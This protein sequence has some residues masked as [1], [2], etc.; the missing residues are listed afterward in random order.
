MGI[1]FMVL[2]PTS[3]L[4]FPATRDSETRQALCRAYN[5]YQAAMFR[6]FSDRLAP[7]AVIPMRTPE[8]AVRELEHA[9]RVLG[10]KAAMIPGYVLR[11]TQNPK[12]GF[13]ERWMDSYGIDSPY[14]YDPVWAKCVELGIPPASHGSTNG[15]GSRK[16]IS[17]FT[18]NGIGN[19][20]SMGEAICKSLFMGGVTRRFPTLN[21]GFMEG[22]VAWAA[23]LYA[24]LVFRWRKR[25]P[26]ALL[27]HLDPD[28]LDLESLMGYFDQYG[29]DSM[30]RLRDEI[31]YLFALKEPRMENIDDWAACKIEREEDLR[32]LFEPH[33][34]F[35]C[36][37]EDPLVG[38]AFNSKA[39]PLGARLRPVFGSDIGHWDVTEMSEVVEEAY[40]SVEHGLMTEEDFRDFVFTNPVR[41]YGTMNPNIFKGTV[42][43]AQA[44]K[45]LAERT[46]PLVKA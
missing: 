38:L 8:E 40:E 35:G 25:N 12:G 28:L 23:E 3:G 31:R 10:L 33:F 45:A 44:A 34:Y 32:D 13:G 16:S 41:M 29:G 26:K 9:V 27:E 1:D 11:R 17:S 24:Q 36:E 6:E 14:N 22:G 43:E 4:R 42:V 7:V 18:Y 37:G 39:N 15:W 46:Q 21:V 19:F 20:G 30:R 2:Y 5:T